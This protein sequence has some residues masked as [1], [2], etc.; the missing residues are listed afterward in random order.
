MKPMKP[1][2]QNNVYIYIHLIYSTLIGSLYA[3]IGSLWSTRSAS[4]DSLGVCGP[5]LKNL[6]SG[7]KGH[8]H[9]SGISAGAWDYCGR[10]G[11]RLHLQDVSGMLSCDLRAPLSA[12]WYVHVLGASSW[13]WNS[14][15]GAAGSSSATTLREMEDN[16]SAGLRGLGALADRLIISYLKGLE[17]V[18]LKRMPWGEQHQSSA[19][20]DELQRDCY[21]GQ[22]EWQYFLGI[23]C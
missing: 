17:P 8:H 16:F 13:R 1:A 9:E 3:L 10:L 23:I 12:L 20:L 22:W 19:Q 7:E 14:G 15:P 6:C 21:P 2:P 4:I 5:Q 18:L 11:D